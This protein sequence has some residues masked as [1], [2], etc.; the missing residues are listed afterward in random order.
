MNDKNGRDLAKC[1]ES[2]TVSA[3]ASAYQVVS[4]TA[5]QLYAGTSYLTSVNE[6][7][8][9]A[10]R[11]G[12][13][14]NAAMANSAYYDG[15]GR[16]IS[17]LPDSAAVS[18][19]ASSYVE[20]SVSSKADSSALSSYAL[21][22]DVS[23]CIDT[24]SSNSASWGGGGATGDYVEKSAIMV[25]I[26]SGNTSY[27]SNSAV[28]I[29]GYGNNNN[30]NNFV[31]IQ[32][33]NCTAGDGTTFLQGEQNSAG[34]SYSFAQG[35]TN[36]S[37]R[38][39]VQG[40]T[41]TA[42]AYSLA[43]GNENQAYESSLAQGNRNTASSYS[44]AQGYL[45]QAYGDSFA[46]GVNNKAYDSSMAQGD[47]NIASSDSM[48]QGYYNRAYGDS[49][50]QGEENSA[51]S[52]SVSLGLYN[53]ANGYSIAH[54]FRNSAFNFGVAV[55]MYN[56]AANTAAVFGQYNLHGDGDVSTGD[57][58]AFV[59]GD[60]T[61][62]AARH[63]LMVVTKDG[64][65]RTY[66][67]TSD[68]AGFPIRSAILAVSAAAT[69]GA[70]TLPITGTD[71][72]QDMSLDELGLHITIP[73][74]G[75][76]TNSA[77]YGQA[78]TVGSTGDSTQTYVGPNVVEFRDT[79]NSYTSFGHDE[80]S[81]WNDV[82]NTVSSNS[83]S[84]TGGGGGN[85]FPV[86]FDS[87]NCSAELTTGYYVTTGR[88][89][90]VLSSIDASIYPRFIV[91]N[92][93]ANSKKGSYYLS[94]AFEFTT[95]SSNNSGTKVMR[96]DPQ[97]ISSK[98]FLLYGPSASSNTYGSLYLAGKNADARIQL[99][100]G[101]VEHT[102]YIRPS[103]I[104]SWWD[105][106]DTVSAGSASW[107]ASGI[108]SATCSAIASSYAESA[109]SSVSGNYA[110]SADISA[111]IDLVNTQSANWGGSALELSAGP[112]VTLTKSGSVLV[113][114]TD[115]TVL[116]S[117]SASITTAGQTISLSETCT[118]FDRIRIYG[119]NWVGWTPT[120]W[121]EVSG[122]GPQFS[123]VCSYLGA[124]GDAV[125]FCQSMWTVSGTDYEISNCK[126]FSLQGATAS[127]S[128]PVNTWVRLVVGVNR[129]ANN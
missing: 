16:L 95:G 86:T 128:T 10:S 37:K 41:N 117:G 8:I 38:S 125:R 118:N 21:S 2:A 126:V 61:D 42:F 123:L 121:G 31:F 22:A 59:I 75:Y 44:L 24:V 55:G 85:P 56:T 62:T 77:E 103:A 104:S 115:E 11:A 7:P 57:S 48:A 129:T 73:D 30:G 99:G 113:A 4:A 58:A 6:A 106:Y 27:T 88:P 64:E 29:Q 26:G 83:A 119:E 107:T 96:V 45:N 15:T 102:N 68:T 122:S 127:T 108:D 109:V 9:S 71:G 78:M 39:L 79:A 84:W 110:Q 111:T 89:S 94:D 33:R 49:F 47:S 50:A 46:Q 66:S 101:N 14:A 112:G 97:Q 54:G 82:Y 69:G 87:G 72:D 76:G 92:G 74:G 23:G 5:T 81:A 51:S 12:N 114:S 32:G 43:Q 63:D 52:V 91:T 19:I 34:D 124:G 36:R 40:T 70:V 1:V 18:S 105:V 120:L 25:D 20:A 60:G 28:F 116:W 100:S 35:A 80:V 67:S 93:T 53:N 13:A 90:F 65:I 3:I 17:A 98:N